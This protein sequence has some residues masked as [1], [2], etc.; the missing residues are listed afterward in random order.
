MNHKTIVYREA[1]KEDIPFMKEMLI[2]ACRASGVTSITI[3]NLHKYRD[4][5]INIEGWDCKVEPGVIAIKECG[6]PVGAIWLRN[7]PELGHSVNGYLPEITIAVSFNYRQQ[8]IAGNLL[9][10]FYQK[11][12]EKGIFRISLGVHS[13][14]I[15]AIN[16]YKKQGWQQDGTFKDYIMMSK[17]IK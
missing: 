10:I 9:R 15:P 8:G 11:C 1:T 5:E 3:D 14:N 17:Q 13:E 4:T 16:L 6:E 2:E 12:V 7:L